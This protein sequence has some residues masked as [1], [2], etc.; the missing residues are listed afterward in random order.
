MTLSRVRR[1]A[2]AAI[3]AAAR[4]IAKR[5]DP[6]VHDVHAVRAETFTTAG[7]SVLADPCVPRGKGYVTG[8]RTARVIIE[9]AGPDEPPSAFV[10][11]QDESPRVRPD[12]R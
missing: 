7:L 10:M 3:V 9:T 8:R 11:G 5:L 2:A 4:C 1:W 6:A 12:T